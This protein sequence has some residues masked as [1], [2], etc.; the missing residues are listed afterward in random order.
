VAVDETQTETSPGGLSRLLA[1]SGGA[2]LSYPVASGTSGRLADG[3]R[4]AD[5]TWIDVTGPDGR[6]RYHDD[7]W[8]TPSA[9]ARAATRQA[10]GS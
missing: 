2:R 10:S 1:R 4:V 8:L 5:L 3:Y 9:L 6:I 7:G